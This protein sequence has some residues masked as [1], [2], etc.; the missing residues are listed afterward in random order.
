[1][2]RALSNLE[3]LSVHEA[4]AEDITLC[5]VDSAAAGVPD[6]A[7]GA[8]AAGESVTAVITANGDSINC[9]AAVLTTGTFLRG[10]IHVGEV[11]CTAAL[12]CAVVP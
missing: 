3:G 12:P 5:A 4:A 9:K 1:M 7:G 11:S 10:M 8:G 2:Q 6:E